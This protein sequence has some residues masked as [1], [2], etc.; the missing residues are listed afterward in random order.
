[1]ANAQTSRIEELA[2]DDG[3][4]PVRM[5]FDVQS[6]GVN[7]WTAK[8]AGDRLIGE[9]DEIP[10]GHEELY[11]I[12]AGR[13]TFTVDGEEID[14]GPGTVVF[15]SDPALKRGAIAQDAGTT[16]FA[17]GGKPGEAYKPRAWE[18]NALVFP[19]FERG[20]LDEAKEILNEALGRYD[21]REGLL[22]NLACAEARL[23]EAD[24]AFEH[25]AAA[26]AG[27][28]DLAD[29]ARGD[30]DL[31]PLRDD[32]RFVELVPAVTVEK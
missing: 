7:A 6:F 18:T 29:L 10:S 4:S 1:M 17:V 30:D 5:H 13:A 25:L 28:P 21:D 3:W 14:A 19:L 31:A 23:G 16:V 8:D 22:Y 9:H 11:L 32:P 24:Q 2:R 12:T 26:L 27:R 15:V 20:E